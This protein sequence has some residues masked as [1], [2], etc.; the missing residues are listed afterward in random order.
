MRYVQAEVVSLTILSQ[1]VWTVF[2]NRPNFALISEISDDLSS[3]ALRL[4]SHRHS[5]IEFS[6]TTT[7]GG[8]FHCFRGR[9]PAENKDL[10]DAT[11]MK[12]PFHRFRGNVDVTF[13]ALRFGPQSLEILN[14]AQDD[15]ENPDQSRTSGS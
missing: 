6:V 15:E 9:V 2:K 14:H 10:P 7:M 1:F 12:E 8:P 11:T 5:Y 13:T 3:F 4:M